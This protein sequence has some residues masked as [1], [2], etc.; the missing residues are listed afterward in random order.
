M[1]EIKFRVWDGKKFGYIHLQSGVGKITLP[2][3]DFMPH[4]YRDFGQIKLPDSTIFQ[5]YTGLHDRNEK[6]IYEGDVMT[7]VDPLNKAEIFWND[8]LARFCRRIDGNSAF[9]NGEMANNGEVIGNIYENP[10]LLEAS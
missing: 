10:E 6:E 5:Q 9:F 7:F 4:E 3:V 2:G 8:K 1:R